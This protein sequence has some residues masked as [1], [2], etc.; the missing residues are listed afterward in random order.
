MSNSRLVIN[1]VIFGLTDA[2]HILQKKFGLDI[3]LVLEK[4]LNYLFMWN[5]FAMLQLFAGW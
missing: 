1:W 2:G 4:F 5:F 3:Q